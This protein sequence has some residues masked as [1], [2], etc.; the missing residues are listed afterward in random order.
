MKDFGAFPP[1]KYL[2]AGVR[3][4]IDKLLDLRE[5]CDDAQEDLVT[6][7]AKVGE[8][9]T[10]DIMAAANAYVA[11]KEDAGT[12]HHD[13]A[14]QAVKDAERRLR[15]LKAAVPQV[16][17]E[18]QRAFAAAGEEICATADAEYEQA[19]AAYIQAVEALVSARAE[20][21]V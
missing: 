15:V 20:W 19:T 5:H 21:V 7:R 6:A 13:A 3:K 11:G 2:P 12:V 18:L 9:E 4:A 1:D 10:A 16:T 17:A 8:A 14:I